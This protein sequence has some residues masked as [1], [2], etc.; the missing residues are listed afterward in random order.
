VQNGGTQRKKV[1][2]GLHSQLQVY[3]IQV[4]LIPI[5]NQSPDRIPTGQPI[6]SLSEVCRVST[7]GWFVASRFQITAR[8]YANSWRDLEAFTEP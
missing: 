2:N 4:Y 6:Q 8:V 1:V 3:Q 5:Y 7:A